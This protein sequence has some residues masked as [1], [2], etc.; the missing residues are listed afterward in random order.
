MSLNKKVPKEVSL[1]GKL[2]LP[3]ETPF[4]L[5]IPPRRIAGFAPFAYAFY[6]VRIQKATVCLLR[7]WKRKMV[8][9]AR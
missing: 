4:P 1:R 7:R 9:T 3:R 5:R 2:A 8:L 6:G